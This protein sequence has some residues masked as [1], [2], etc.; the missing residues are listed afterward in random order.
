M[1]KHYQLR[2]LYP[3]TGTIIS[4]ILFV[5]Y[6]NIG[7]NNFFAITVTILGLVI[8]WTASIT[9]GKAFALIPKTSE[10]IQ[11]GIYSKI[12]HPIYVGFSMTGIGW[13]ILSSFIRAKKEEKKFVKT[14]GEKYLDYKKNTWF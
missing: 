13:A 9:L 10:L 11:A 3:L 12:K 4:A 5:S 6:W 2:N 14:F 7:F 8:W 1:I